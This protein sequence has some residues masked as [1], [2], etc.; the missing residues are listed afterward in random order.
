MTTTPILYLFRNI[1]TSQVLVSTQRNLI[2]DQNRILRQITDVTVRPPRIRPD[3]W[4]PMVVA[5]GFPSSTESQTLQTVLAQ[6][7]A[8]LKQ[9]TEEE[10][11]KHMLLPISKRKIIDMDMIE[12]K[13]AHLCRALIYFKHTDS[14]I[15]KNDINLYWERPEYRDILNGSNLL[16]PEFVQHKQLELVRGNIICN[17][18]LKRLS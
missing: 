9:P 15:V 8:P 12:S 1:K 17:P 2:K 18:E 7:S 3:L 13:I 11:K 6:T 14:P 5:T 16:W 10:I 4:N